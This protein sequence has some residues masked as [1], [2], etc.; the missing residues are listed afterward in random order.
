[1]LDSEF[2]FLRK[3]ACSDRAVPE[4]VWLGQET[5]RV[6]QYRREIEEKMKLEN[7]SWV[8]MELLSTIID[9]MLLRLTA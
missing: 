7:P 6:E 8:K 5:K 2:E 4:A 9:L 3:L 1:V